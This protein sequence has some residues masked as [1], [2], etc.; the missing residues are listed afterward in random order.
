MSSIIPYNSQ[1]ISIL[2]KPVEYA[3]E[4][5]KNRL[6]DA[7]TVWLKKHPKPTGNQKFIAERDALLIEWLWNTGMRI[8]DALS[9]HF[10]DV[11]NSKE[12]CNFF[13]KKG[14]K[15]HTISLDKPILFEVQRFKEMFFFKPEDIIFSMSKQN[16]WMQ[17]DKY[18]KMAGLPEIVKSYVI[19]T[20]NRA[21]QTVITKSHFHPHLLRHGMAMDDMKNG[22]PIPITSF[23]LAHSSTSV[24]QDIYQR[25][26]Q[27]IERGFRERMKRG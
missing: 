26:D 15:T 8:S 5:D 19:K 23:R 27:N 25:V 18:A 21:G 16:A 11:D 9:L 22:V 14:R 6:K 17:L 3:T 13:V 10:R 7:V 4:E 24:T 1:A 2:K 12:V 20:G